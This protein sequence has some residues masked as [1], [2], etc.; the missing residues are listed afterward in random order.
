MTSLKW[1]LFYHRWVETPEL[2]CEA[3]KRQRRSAAE[4]IE[5]NEDGTIKPVVRTNEGV[6]QFSQRLIE[7]TEK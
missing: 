6:S 3:R 4:F 5:F 2:E 1:I 7:S